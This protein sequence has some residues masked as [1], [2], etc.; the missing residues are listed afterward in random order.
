MHNYTGYVTKQVLLD[1][2][3]FLDSSWPAGYK[4]SRSQPIPRF[5]S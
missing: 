1:Q 3:Q 5:I 2:S 4:Q